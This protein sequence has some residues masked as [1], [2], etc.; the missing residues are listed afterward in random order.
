MKRGLDTNETMAEIIDEA[1]VEKF[2]IA[3]RLIEDSGT[4]KVKKAPINKN[5]SYNEEN[6]SVIGGTDGFATSEFDTEEDAQQF[7]NDIQIL[8]NNELTERYPKIWV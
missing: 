4:Y 1:I 5:R 2:D 8:D 3:I 6:F 7:F